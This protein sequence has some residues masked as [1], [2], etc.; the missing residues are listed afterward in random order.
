MAHKRTAEIGHVTLTTPPFGGIQHQLYSRRL[1]MPARVL[2][3]G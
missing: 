3:N 2:R 1:E